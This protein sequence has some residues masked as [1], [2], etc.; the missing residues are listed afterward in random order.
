MKS[1]PGRMVR[2]VFRVGGEFIAGPEACEAGPQTAP[3]K[4]GCAS[5]VRDTQASCICHPSVASRS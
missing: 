1:A 3:G 4:P 2:S 5:M